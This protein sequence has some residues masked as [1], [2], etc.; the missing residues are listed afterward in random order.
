M[1]LQQLEY[2][3]AVDVHRHFAKAAESIYVTQPTLSM[4]IRKLEDELGVRIFERDR[5]PVVPTREGM[6]IVERARHILAEVD[7]LREYAAGL[8]GEIS[9]ELRLGIIP[10]LA[11]YLLPLFLKSFSETYPKLKLHIKE[12]VTDDIIMLLRR[13]E[14]DMGL[15]ATPLDEPNL[16][17]YPVFQEEFYA[18]V[19][20]NEGFPQKKYVLPAHIDPSK[21]WLLQEGHCLRNQIFNLCELKNTDFG[22]AVWYEAGSIETLI[23]LVDHHG[24]ITI[25]PQLATL[26]LKT[27]QKKN[28]REFSNPKPAREISLVT[29][30][31]FPRR[32]LLE[33]LRAEIAAKI[34]IE[35]N[36]G[37]K[38]LVR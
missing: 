18:Y 34:P 22:T 21:L 35:P 29:T 10:T 3:V 38:V 37:L 1:N 19:S 36:N 7:K 16:C 17:E 5:K 31:N 33:S 12:A 9:G 15:L 32:M 6:E 14:M 24:G 2:V 8:S 23:N 25:I 27:H 4:M 28:L 11:P 20:Q 30:K 26:H 13:G